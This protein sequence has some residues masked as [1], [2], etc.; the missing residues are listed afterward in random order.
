MATTIKIKRGAAAS[1]TA[2]SQLAAGELAVTYGDAS[3]YNNG[4]DRLYIG[5]STAGANLVIGGKYF[6]DLLDHA[7]GTLTASS[8]APNVPGAVSEVAAPLLILI[9]V[10]IFYL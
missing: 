4:G 10:A 6:A 1:E 5:N 3:A 7:P 9:V 8:P 2:P